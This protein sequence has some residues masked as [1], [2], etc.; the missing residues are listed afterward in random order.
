MHGHKNNF[1]VMEAKALSFMVS[2][3]ILTFTFQLERQICCNY[4]EK[5]NKEQI[6]VTEAD[7]GISTWYYEIILSTSASITQIVFEIIHIIYN[8]HAQ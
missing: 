6:A 1:C 7:H 5:A 4:Y 3:P 2:K 8:T